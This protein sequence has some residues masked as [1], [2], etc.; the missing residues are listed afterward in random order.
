VAHSAKRT[1]L[2]CRSVNCVNRKGF[3]GLAAE[4]IF[5]KKT[6]FGLFLKLMATL[7][8]SLESF[9]VNIRD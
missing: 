8:L 5:V 2:L 6:F 9:M 4:R 7:L 1:G 3:I